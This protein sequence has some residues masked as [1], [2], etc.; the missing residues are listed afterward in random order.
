[1]GAPSRGSGVGIRSRT[2]RSALGP[3]LNGGAVR[4][5]G[6]TGRVAES[7]CLGRSCHLAFGSV[8]MAML[9]L[10]FDRYGS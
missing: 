5:P 6:T 10:G 4:L 8:S 3:G 9:Y 1:M 2:S 7:C